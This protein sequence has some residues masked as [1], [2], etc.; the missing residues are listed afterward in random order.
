M[1]S[2][3]IGSRLEVARACGIET[4]IDPTETPLA[5]AVAEATGG[6]GADV[7]VEATGAP[8]LVDEAIRTANRFGEV[9]LLGSTRGVVEID[10]YATV[11]KRTLT[12]TGAHESSIAPF[13]A[14]PLGHSMMSIYGEVLELIA[15]GR[16][17]TAPLVTHTV[18]PEDVKDAYDGLNG[19]KDAYLGVLIDWRRG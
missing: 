1:I 8:Q 16:L 3:P 15:A 18:P 9:I 7:V 19:N 2:D 17:V 13:Q 11:H 12:V 10:V 6:A 5:G 14:G 4:V